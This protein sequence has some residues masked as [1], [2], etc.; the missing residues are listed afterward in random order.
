M[1][2]DKKPPVHSVRIGKIRAAIWENKT[3]NGVRHNVTL[4]RIY[5]DDEGW[6]DT[7]S[8]GRDDL[9]LVGKVANEAHTWIHAQNN[10]SSNGEQNQEEEF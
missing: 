2:K 9:L 8:F 7:G 6:K 10:E 3:D 5:K 1:A 4:S